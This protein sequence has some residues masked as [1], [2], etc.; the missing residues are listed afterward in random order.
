M[1]QT[2]LF[3]DLELRGFLTNLDFASPVTPPQPEAQHWNQKSTFGDFESF[4]CLSTMVVWVGS[5]V[6]VHAWI[7]LIMWILLFVWFVFFCVSLRSAIMRKILK[8]EKR[9]ELKFLDP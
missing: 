4:G 2:L 3:D 9:H 1:I 6:T 8:C 7:L 5:K